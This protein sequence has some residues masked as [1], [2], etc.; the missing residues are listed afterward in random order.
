MSIV[1]MDGL[2]HYAS[3]SDLLART[4]FTELEDA[5]VNPTGGRFGGTGINASGDS[6]RLDI[7]LPSAQ[8]TLRIAWAFKLNGDHSSYHSFDV[9]D[10]GGSIGVNIQYDSDRILKIN[11][12]NVVAPKL[13]AWAWYE[14]EIVRGS[15]GS[16][17]VYYNGTEVYNASINTDTNGSDYIKIDSDRGKYYHFGS[18]D[19][20]DIVIWNN[21]GT[22]LTSFPIGDKRIFTAR[23][24]AIG[25]SSDFTPNGDSSNELTV[26]DPSG[27]DGDTTYN[28][29]GTVGDRD[30]FTVGAL[31]SNVLNITAVQVFSIAR[32]D[33]VD[34][35]SASNVLKSGTTVDVNTAVALADNYDAYTSVYTQNPDT[36]A[37]F[38]KTEVDNIEIGYEVAS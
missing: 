26:D 3:A 31:P 35:R 32:K 24:D 22:G 14:F 34:A 27:F 6:T 38:T 37:A 12:N 20:D 30:L 18:W 28:S 7:K 21:D 9:Q 36:N 2:D 23:P 33:D 29:S 4:E 19:M 10:A 8:S 5:T 16:V 17:K 1:L 11:G 13:D 15:P 25:S